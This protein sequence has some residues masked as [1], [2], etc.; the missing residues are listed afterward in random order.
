MAFIARLF[1]TYY[2][3]CWSNTKG[4]VSTA[5]TDRR[6]FYIQSRTSTTDFRGYRNGAQIGATNTTTQPQADFDYMTMSLGIFCFNQGNSQTNFSKT[7]QA[8]A[9]MG[10]GLTTTEAGNF[11]RA[12]QR[13]QQI[14]G[15][16][17]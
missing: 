1:N 3:D 8:F 13:Y 4:R 14:L 15:R 9:F 6:G 10:D 17:V 16:A 5:N 7:E 12:V 11:N 2:A